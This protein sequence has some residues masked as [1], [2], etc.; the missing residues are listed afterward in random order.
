[1]YLPGYA[2]VAWYHHVLPE[3]PPELEPFLDE[4]RAY[5]MG[6]FSVALNKGGRSRRTSGPNSPSNFTST[7][8]L[9]TEYLL[10]A[11]FR[12]SEIAF[13]HEL[14]KSRGLTLGRLDARFAGPTQDPL[15]KD[16]DYDPQ[17]SSIG[18]AFVAAFQDYYHGE[19]NSGQGKTYR[20]SNDEVGD[21]WKWPHKIAG[22]GD[23]QPIVNSGVDLSQALVQDPNLRVLVLNGYYDLATPFSA[24]EYVMSHLA[25]RSLR[26]HIRW[27]TTR[28]AT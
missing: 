9:A 5:A 25:C 6:P 15:A 27:S 17:A 1:M 4:V 13:V 10:A 16:T 26:S 7:P 28:R 22:T 23:E 14:L 21:K 24:T 18:A 11:D 20:T 12:V 8:G 19:L 3:Q 2:A